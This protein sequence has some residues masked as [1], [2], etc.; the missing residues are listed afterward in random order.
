MLCFESGILFLFDCLNEFEDLNNVVI[1]YLDEGAYKRFNFFFVVAGYE[2]IVC[3]KVCEGIKCI[4]KFKEGEL[5]GCY[6]VIV[7]DFV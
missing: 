4:V 1:A 7:D 5:I 3:I 6:V 2:C